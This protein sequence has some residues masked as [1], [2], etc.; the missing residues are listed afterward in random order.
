MFSA[1]SAG[2]APDSLCFLIRFAR[3]SAQLNPA[4]PAPT[5]STSASSCSRRTVTLLCF[6]QLFCQR[7]HNLKNV[8][9]HAVICDL[10]NRGVLVLVDGN[11]GAR[12]LH[13][14]HVLNRAA[15]S[16]RQI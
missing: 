12:T 7:G 10:K 1:E 11:D 13:S 4:G 5:I 9:D 8:T 16:Q 6:L 3:C 14:N 2:L 15:D